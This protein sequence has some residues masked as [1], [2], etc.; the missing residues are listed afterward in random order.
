MV[1][2][3]IAVAGAGVFGAATALELC[4][5]GHAV[6]LLDPGPLPRPDAASTDSSRMVRLDYGADAVYVALME[7]ALARWRAWNEAWRRA[8]QAELFHEDGLLVLSREPLAPGGFE[9]DSHALLAARGH[10]LQ[11]LTPAAL[12]A[13][14]PA[15]A[16]G[17]FA[18]GYWNAQGGWA[19]AG[20]VTAWLAQAARDAGVELR[21][22]WAAAGLRRHGDRVDG[23]L[24]RDAQGRTHELPADLVVL[25]AG[26]WSGAGLPELRDDPPPFRLVAQ[27][28]L[29]LRPARPERFRPPA[30]PPFTADIA[31][32]GWYGFPALPDGRVKLGN[33]GAGF[34]VA[35]ADA[36][37]AAPP[38]AEQRLRE[39]LAAD[40]PELSDAPLADARLCFYTD[41]P[42]GHFLIDEHPRLPGLWIAS[43]GSGHAFK[44]APVL[45]ELV[46]DALL[47]RAD[48]PH[49]AALARCRWRRAAVRHG[50][51][52][53]AGPVA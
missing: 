12:A 34:A 16:A 42:D 30:F 1:G 9:G 6:L 22:G 32:T 37:R 29:Y 33:H 51:A 24:A 27:P 15:F 39:F 18:D 47:A 44:F 36:P 14:H 52:A 7:Q 8:G 23:L 48:S 2:M 10:A 41:T 26:A 17:R 5:R 13:R 40:L 46:A 49:A 45:G 50:D 3:R 35:D 19:E 38:A 43:G 20:H 28:L 31:R 53:R 25:A 21:E 11:R 4:R